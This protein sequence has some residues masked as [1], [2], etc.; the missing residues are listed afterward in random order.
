M[1]PD[2][3]RLQ[4][5]VDAM[6]LR[7]RLLLFVSACAALVALADFLVLSPQLQAQRALGQKL[8]AQAS[9]LQA[10][11]AKLQ[12]D[13]TSAAGKLLGEL[14]AL[15]ARRGAIDEQIAQ[16]RGGAAATAQLPALLERALRRHDRLTLLRLG[17]APPAP[18]RPGGPRVQ[19]VELALAGSYP[20]LTR[21]VADTERE[22]PDL[23]WGEV[24]L[25][26]TELG[27]ELRARVVL[28]ETP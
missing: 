20:D 8:K 9:E 28:L 21:Y 2:W 14:Q 10:L 19:A 18:L 24:S 12:G 1:T 3:K 13:P 5:R 4:Q 17:A 16:K 25:T 26:A 15:Q 22:L 23:R 27:A 7:E 11:R 6:S